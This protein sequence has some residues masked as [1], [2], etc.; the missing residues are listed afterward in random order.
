MITTFCGVES[1]NV[2]SGG[3]DE[4]RTSLALLHGFSPVLRSLYL[5]FMSLPDSEIFGLVCSF[6]LLED[7]TLVSFGCGRMGGEWNTPSTSPPIP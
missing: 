6:P 3:R 2:L 7:L 4:N 5:S 1:L